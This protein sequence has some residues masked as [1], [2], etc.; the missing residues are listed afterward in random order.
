LEKETRESQ[1]QVKDE[2]IIQSAEEKNVIEKEP[3]QGGNRQSKTQEE[4]NKKQQYSRK[5]LSDRISA[6]LSNQ[7]SEADK[8]ED[9]NEDANSEFF[10]L[11]KADKVKETK[12]KDQLS[13]PERTTDKDQADEQDFEVFELEDKEQQEQSQKSE[14]KVYYS[15]TYFGEDYLKSIY[16]RKEE[17]SDDLIDQFIKKNPELEVKKPQES[18]IEDISEES[19]QEKEDFLSEKLAHVYLKQG[20]YEK[21]LQAFEKLSLK[22]PEKSDYFADQIKKIKQIINKQ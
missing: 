9:A 6:T 20:Y 4:K 1:E 16:P 18:E 22:Y 11:D 19:I 2:E 3:D 7:I 12:S 17:E 14:K 5:N 13:Q 15:E 21:A 8:K 10:I